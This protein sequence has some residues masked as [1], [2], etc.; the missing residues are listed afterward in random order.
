MMSITDKITQRIKHKRRGWVFGPGDFLDV[1]SRA[2]VDQ[3]LSRLVKQNMIR[4][5]DRGIYDYPKQ[6]KLFGTLSP[7]PDAIARVLA[8]GDVIFPSGA[9]AANMLGLST[10]VPMKI[11]YFTNNTSKTRTIGT[12][13]IALKRAKVP[14]MK[15]VSDKINL[16]LQALTYLGNINIDNQVID[17]C[18]SLLSDD[19]I[20]TLHRVMYKLPGWLADTIHKIEYAKYG[21]IQHAA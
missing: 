14:L 8:G 19:D 21:Q 10:Q 17:S 15:R 11:V 18:A 9:T 7:A 13:R 2:A 5:L 12:Q 20:V 3:V 4:R 16:M 6:S 1:G